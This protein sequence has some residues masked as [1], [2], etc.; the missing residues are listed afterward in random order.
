MYIFAPLCKRKHTYRYMKGNEIAHLPGELGM[1]GQDGDETNGIEG[2][3]DN[4]SLR[5]TLTS[6]LD[7]CYV[8]CK[9]LLLFAECLCPQTTHILKH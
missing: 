2:I 7:L 3:G 5:I 6:V 4:S 1:C 9:R 8:S